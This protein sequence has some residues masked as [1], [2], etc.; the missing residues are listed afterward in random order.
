[1]NRYFAEDLLTSLY[2]PIYEDPLNSC[3]TMFIEQFIATYYGH[4]FQGIQCS[5][6]KLLYRW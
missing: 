1:M 4:F 3:E 2:A 5:F 6:S